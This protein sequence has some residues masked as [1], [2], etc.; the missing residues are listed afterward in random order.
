MCDMSRSGIASNI[1]WNLAYH[2][3]FQYQRSVYLDLSETANRLSFQAGPYPL[4]RVTCRE[5]GGGQSTFSEYIGYRPVMDLEN[6]FLGKRFSDLSGTE[7]RVLKFVLSYLVLIFSCKPF[8][9]GVDS[10]RFVFQTFDVSAT[11]PE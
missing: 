5:K 4:V 3:V 1:K 9:M 6:A 10:M 2:I 8:G 7:V 11:F